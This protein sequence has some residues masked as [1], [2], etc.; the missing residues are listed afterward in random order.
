MR[1]A[2]PSF[3]LVKV[4][5]SHYIEPPSMIISWQHGHRQFVGR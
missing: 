4:P 2:L 5:G 1:N 3:F